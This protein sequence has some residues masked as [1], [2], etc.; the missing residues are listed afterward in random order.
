MLHTAKKKY[1]ALAA[2]D[3]DYHLVLP[4]KR[5]HR[6]GVHS[7]RNRKPGHRSMCCSNDSSA[8]RPQSLPRILPSLL[9]HLNHHYPFHWLISARL[10]EAAWTW[11]E[12]HIWLRDR[13]GI[14]AILVVSCI[15]LF[16]SSGPLMLLSGANS[17]IAVPPLLCFQKVIY[18]FDR[19]REN[20]IQKVARCCDK[21][22]LSLKYFVFCVKLILCILCKSCFV[23]YVKLKGWEQIWSN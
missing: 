8:R 22:S 19:R 11:E 10:F 15:K 12:L 1:I 2:S 21:A 6:K 14:K 18:K 17:W 3:V 9:C 13:F 16:L 23:F 20:S 7:K 5:K 4:L